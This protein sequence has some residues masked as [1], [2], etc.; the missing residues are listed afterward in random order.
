VP[1]TVNQ[2]QADGIDTVFVLAAVVT[3]TQFVQQA[4]NQGYRPAYHL[5]DW[6]NNNSDFTVQNMPSSFDGNIG[7]TQIWGHA[8]K[9]PYGKE[10]PQAARCRQIHDKYSGRKL[11][12]RGTAEYGATMQN[13]DSLLAFEKAARAAGADLTRA[14]LTAAVPTLGSYPIA[15]WGPGAFG[16]GKLDYS[17]QVRFQ[18]YRSSCTCWQPS[19]G[20]FTPR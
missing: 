3:A 4:D 12:S 1:V 14:R 8:N 17:D 10:N 11:Q 9:S 5:T 20:F 2:F 19:G 13:C 6:A 15:N 18:V 7:T 16:S